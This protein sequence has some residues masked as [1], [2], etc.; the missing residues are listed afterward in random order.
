MQPYTG[1]NM[2]P[3]RNKDEEK[4]MPQEGRKGH[5]R[6]Q[7]TWQSQRDLLA[8][9]HA[10]APSA[11][12]T[13]LQSPTELSSLLLCCPGSPLQGRQLASIISRFLEPH[14]GGVQLPYN[15]S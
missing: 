8:F 7:R 5:R 11:L 4:Y 1:R 6:Q 9:L 15:S 10:D 14:S 13:G 3:R 2:G 12:C